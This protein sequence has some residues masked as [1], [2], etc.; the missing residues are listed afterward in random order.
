MA[1]IKVHFE[2]KIGKQPELQGEGDKAWVQVGV[3]TERWVGEGKG[4]VRDYNG[5]QQQTAYKT[6]WVNIVAFGRQAQYITERF[7]PGDTIVINDGELEVSVYTKKDKQSG[8]VIDDKAV[9]L[10]VIARDLSG[11][12]RVVPKSDNNGNGNGGNGNHQQAPAQ[13]QQAP[14]P[15]QQA[16][17]RQGAASRTQTAAPAARTQQRQAAPAAVQPAQQALIDDDIPF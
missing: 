17:P 3:A 2:G 15:R 4:D 16:A 9:G 5:Q 10:R 7:S 6:T 1:G 11:P 8:N 14:A 12:F 13:Q